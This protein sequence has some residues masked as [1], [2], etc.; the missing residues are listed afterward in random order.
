MAHRMGCLP[1]KRSFSFGLRPVRR[2][3]LGQFTWWFRFLLKG[4]MFRLRVEHSAL[5]LI[6]RYVP[7]MMGV[8][9]SSPFRQSMTCSG[10]SAVQQRR[11]KLFMKK[12]LL[13]ESQLL[14]LI[15]WLLV[16]PSFVCGLSAAP[17][18]RSHA[19][20]FSVVWSAFRRKLAVASF[21][22][23]WTC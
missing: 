4:F 9:C 2:V 16:G 13:Q 5:M 10:Q 21:V 23:N 8:C 22:L 3:L 11:H 20:P 18:S 19:A 6:R 1:E 7:W 15:N 17:L 12:R 14:T